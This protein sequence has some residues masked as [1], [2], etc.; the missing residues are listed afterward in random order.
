MKRFFILASAAIVALASCAKT[1]V[2]YKDAPQEIAF[3]ALTGAVTRAEQEG[4]LTGTMGVFAYVHNANKDVYFGNTSFAQAAVGEDPKPWVGGKYW[5]LANDALDFVVYAPY[6]ANATYTTATTTLNVAADNSAKLTIDEQTDYLYGA[7]YYDNT[8]DVG[9]TKME[10]ALP[11]VLKHAQT[12]VTVAFTGKNVTVTEVKL[13][14][15]CLKGSY[16]V[17]YAATPAIDWEPGTPN[18]ALQL[19]ATTGE[20][21]DAAPAVSASILLVPETQSNITF[22][23]QIKGSSATLD[24]TIDNS[25]LTWQAGNHYTFNVDITPLEIKL[26]PSVAGWDGPVEE[27]VVL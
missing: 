17:N 16:K 23:Y 4:T 13:T 7:E 25:S 20:L 27:P 10:T 14:T 21:A 12:K 5:P 1:E 3:K 19:I 15:P 2:V 9:Y 26:K 24:Y 22:K 6:D 11:V 8:G 18:A